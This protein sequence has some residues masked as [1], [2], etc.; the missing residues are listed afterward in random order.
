MTT[1]IYANI[2]P[3]DEITYRDGVAEIKQ[4]D[5]TRYGPLRQVARPANNGTGDWT[6]NLILTYTD[7][8]TERVDGHLLNTEREQ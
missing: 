8:R 7:G 6:E 4:T 2:V 5:A 1:E 3:A